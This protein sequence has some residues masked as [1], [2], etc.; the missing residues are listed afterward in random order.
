[1]RKQTQK[2]IYSIVSNPKYNPALNDK[3]KKKK[4]LEEEKEN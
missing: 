3:L 2:T 4:R 1:M